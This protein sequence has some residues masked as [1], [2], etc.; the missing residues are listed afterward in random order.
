MRDIAGAL[1]LS[2]DKK[3]NCTHTHIIIKCHSER[4]KWRS[5][6]G[7]GG[8]EDSKSTRPPNAKSMVRH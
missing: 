4:E 8:G 7:G 5:G 6:G 1:R 2:W 3:F